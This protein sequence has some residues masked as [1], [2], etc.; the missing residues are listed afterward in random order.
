MIFLPLAGNERRRHE[1]DDETRDAKPDEPSATAS[2]KDEDTKAKDAAEDAHATKEQAA[3][4]TH[5]Y[6]VP[7]NFPVK[8]L[9]RRPNGCLWQGH[10]P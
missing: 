5:F 3:K 8:T 1:T 2:G 7:V 4:G 9:F 6:P 10:N